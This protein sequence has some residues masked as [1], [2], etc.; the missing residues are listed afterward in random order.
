MKIIPIQVSIDDLIKNYKDNGDGEY[1]VIM[2]ILKVS[3][4]I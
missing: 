1:S 2:T 4:E 3:Y